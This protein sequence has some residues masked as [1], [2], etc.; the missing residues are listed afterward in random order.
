[1]QRESS[2]RKN[3]NSRHWAW[4]D[5]FVLEV[6]FARHQKFPSISFEF[7]SKKTNELRQQSGHETDCN[8]VEHA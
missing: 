7:C 8:K 5:D 6:K 3:S 4:L 1:M 2:G